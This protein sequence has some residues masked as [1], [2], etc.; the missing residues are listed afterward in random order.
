PL[1]TRQ[2]VSVEDCVGFPM[3]LPDASLDLLRV[4]EE[5][6]D[7]V[8]VRPEPVLICNSYALLRSACAAGLAVAVL[9]EPLSRQS[10]DDRSLRY[11]PLLNARPRTF[12]VFLRQDAQLPPIVQEFVEDLIGVLKELEKESKARSRTGKERPKANKR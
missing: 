8:G 10:N 3:A 6:F 11:V 4:N 1:A 2:E 7:R 12:G 5:T 9:S